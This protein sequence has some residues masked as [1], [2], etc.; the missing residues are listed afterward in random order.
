MGNFIDLTGKKF[1]KLTVIKRHGIT[2]NNAVT[3]ECK[4][5]CGKTTYIEGVHIREGH[6]KSCGCLNYTHRM[7]RTR[8]YQIW[9]KMIDRCYNTKI[10]SY[11]YYGQKGVKVCDKWRTF[12]GFWEDMQDGYADNLSIDRI[13][14]N[15]NYEK[16]NCRWVPFSEQGKNRSNVEIIEYNG[17]KH[18]LREWAM[19]YG[20]K[21]RTLHQRVKQYN[22][23]IEKALTT[24]I[25]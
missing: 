9:A 5:E 12:E 4:C 17:E 1:G 6:T 22:W 18:N 7:S 3:W 13:D 15:G 2:K 21:Y 11:K 19:L 23:P 20:F 10:K 24:P 14:F 25:K 8:Q 16:L